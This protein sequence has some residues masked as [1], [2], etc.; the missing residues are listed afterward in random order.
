MTHVVVGRWGKNL[1]IRVPAEIARVAGLTDGEDVEIEAI[2]GDLLIRRSG[3]R[4][5]SLAD[6][7]AAAAEII[8]D[9]TGR[10]LGGV[11]LRELREDGRRE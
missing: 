1:A 10:S 7:E 6:A 9:A 5:Q 8:A 11:S 4:A 2:D 3:A